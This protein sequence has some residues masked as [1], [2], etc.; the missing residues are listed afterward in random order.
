M[1]QV[2]L[3]GVRISFVPRHSQCGFSL[4]GIFPAM[5]ANLVGNK[6]LDLIVDGIKKNRVQFQMSG[7]DYDRITLISHPKYYAVHITR[8]S[9]AETPTHEV[10][11][12]VRGIVE[13]TLKTVSS[14]MNY[15]FCAEYQLSF[16]CPSHPGRDHLCTVKKDERPPHIMLCHNKSD[17]LRPV[18]MQSQ[19]LAWF[20][21]VS[22]DS[23]A[24]VQS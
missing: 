2:S 8:E 11:S 23:F 20:G 9:F 6:A 24:C 19:H 4:I 5:I 13:S 17:D 12:A 21:K 7:G 3:T 10:C 15:S 18:K 1:M 16:E 22:N 14:R